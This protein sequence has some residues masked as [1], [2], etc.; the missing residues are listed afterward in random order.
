MQQIFRLFRPGVPTNTP[1]SGYLEPEP[2]VAQPAASPPNAG[3]SVVGLDNDSNDIDVNPS[4]PVADIDIVDDE[5]EFASP[6]VTAQKKRGRPSFGSSSA[7]DTPARTT[8]AKTPKSGNSTTKTPKSGK[9][10]VASKPSER[11]RK[12][13]DLE[14]DDEN[15]VEEPAAKNRGRPVRTTGAVASARL[16]A[17]AAKKP[18]RGRPKS[19]EVRIL[20]CHSKC[21]VPDAQDRLPPQRAS[22]ALPRRLPPMTVCPRTSGRLRPLWSPA[23]TQTAWS[24]CTL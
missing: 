20:P 5:D 13:A 16:A 23:S 12:A 15:N 19:T 14:E 17:R 8:V 24:T 10:T 4:T 11:K 3:P 2:A 6:P 1:T 18:T 22:V 21:H 9:S 7:S